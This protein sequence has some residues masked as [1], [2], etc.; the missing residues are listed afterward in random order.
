[1]EFKSKILEI[2]KCEDEKNCFNIIKF[3]KPEEFDFKSGQF[4][5]IST[6]DFKLRNN[7]EQLK[8]SSFSIAS[9]P[10]QKDL[11]LCI[12]ILDSD[13]LTNHLAK[14]KKQGNEVNV[15][16]PFGNFVLNKE[17]KEVSFVALGTGIAPMI[18]M[19]R[20]LLHE[21][22]E[23]PINL[24]YGFRNRCCF[25]YH[26]ELMEMQKK[27]PNFN[28]NFI[29]SDPEQD[30]D[31]P[32]GFVQDLIDK[33][34][35]SVPKPEIDFYMCGPPKALESIKEFLIE[36]GFNKDKIFYEKWG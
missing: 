11:E 23:R 9:A 15:K 24:F 35:F 30:W 32:K 3:D 34:D 10:F 36:K 25:L 26:E 7:P 17:F 12:R 14:T 5:M 16:G 4:V 6:D 31:V 20:T 27:F 19:I 2:K 28:L 18:S 33:A 29:P 22:D 8:W 21:N 13:G 1:M